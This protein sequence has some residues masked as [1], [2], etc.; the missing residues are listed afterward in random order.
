MAYSIWLLCAI[1]FNW[2]VIC[3]KILTALI[4]M[5][6]L[7]CPRGPWDGIHM[8]LKQVTNQ[9]YLSLS[10]VNKCLTL[11][12]LILVILMM[13]YRKGF[14]KY[15]EMR[16]TPGHIPHNKGIKKRHDSQVTC[17]EP[18]Y[19]RLSKDDFE[20]DTLVSGTGVPSTG[21]VNP[22]HR[23]VYL[24]PKRST[25][26]DPIL[27]PVL[28]QCQEAADSEKS[29]EKTYRIYHRGCLL[30]LFNEAYREHRERASD[31]AGD[32]S[33]DDFSAVKR[34]LAWQERLTCL[35]CGYVSSRKQLYKTIKTSTRGP[36]VADINY[37]LQVGMHHTGISN[38]GMCYILNAMSIPT[39]CPTAM[40]S[41]ANK[42]GDMLITHNKEDMNQI[43]TKIKDLNKKSGLAEDHPIGVQMDARYNN[44]VYSGSGKTPFQ[45]GTQV[46]HVTVE[47]R[48]RKKF[49]IDVTT[50]SMLCP[51]GVRLEKKTGQRPCPDHDGCTANL[52]YTDVIGNEKQWASESLIKLAGDDINVHTIVTDPDSSSYRAGADLY[53]AGKLK[54]K[55]RHQLDTRHLS[56]NQRKMIKKV[57]FSKDMFPGTTVAEK[58]SNQG[59]FA[60]DLA[61]RC[62]AEHAAA[63]HE[64]AGESSKIRR[65]M[66]Y[67]RD[68]IITCYQRDHSLCK[69]HSRIC[70]GRIRSNWFL[71]SAYLSRDFK[72]CPSQTDIDKL[73]Q[74]IDYR[75]GVSAMNKTEDLLN[76]QKTEAVNKAISSTT[77]KNKTFARNHDA[78]VHSGVSGVNRGVSE[79]IARQ[80][81]FVG[82]PLTPGTLAV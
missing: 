46:S 70:K 51:K 48:T 53:D 62:H 68:A 57:E 5:G 6:G 26:P 65:A 4:V 41:A 18:T 36:K 15:R 32:L 69:K 47:T 9:L 8:F 60:D 23:T 3:F 28:D 72:I 76:T 14:K 33:W 43:C 34:G 22:D 80:L 55:P 81:D 77:P 1:L 13:K 17:E 52:K 25:Q 61:S 10:C 64:L 44:P 37:A 67:A 11:N 27:G 79:S 12:K 82:V 2:T 20:L 71:M 40:Q 42:V 21:E 16:F 75:L 63:F 30:D 74:C 24:R 56:H 7:K 38:V 31:C 58:K 78:R 49:V 45:A 29:E 73:V 39:P 54:T 19:V 50:K 66:T 35:T 59:H